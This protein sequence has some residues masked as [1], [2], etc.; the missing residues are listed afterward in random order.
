MSRHFSRSFV[1]FSLNTLAIA[2]LSATAAVAQSPDSYTHQPERFFQPVSPIPVE[3]GFFQDHASTAAEGYLR[4]KAAVI[5]ARGNFRLSEAQA[6]ILRQQ[7]RSLDRENDLQQTAA[8]LTQKKMWEDARL[9]ARKDRAA[10]LATG[11]Q[12]ADQRET[13]VYRDAYRL[14]KFDLD[15]VTGAICWP[16]LLCDEKYAALRLELDQLSHQHYAYNSP[17]MNSAG[18]ITRAVDK[19]STTLRSELSTLPRSEYSA[20]QKF[21]TG[22]KYAAAEQGEKLAKMEAT[23]VRQVAG[24]K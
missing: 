9:Q 15:R 1:S 8:L 24:T 7:A 22:L 13:T 10:Q 21:L 23:P 11:K 20:A 16:T 19:L 17:A 2:L 14:S 6:Q 12:I 18:E 3:Q 4:G 5:Q